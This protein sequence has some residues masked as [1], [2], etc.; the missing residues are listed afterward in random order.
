MLS[1]SMRRFLITEK[2][3]PIGKDRVR[4]EGVGRAPLDPVVRSI[5][6]G[7]PGPIEAIA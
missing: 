6:R 5:G 1:R 3:V 4:A 7:N 2:P